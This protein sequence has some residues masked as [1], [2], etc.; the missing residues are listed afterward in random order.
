MKTA[1]I[2]CFIFTLILTAG[3]VSAKETTEP[4]SSGSHLIV[5]DSNTAG[6]KY[7]LSLPPQYGSKKQRWPLI[8]RLHGAGRRG[9]DLKKIENNML[10]K[11]AREDK[12]FPFIVLCPQCPKGRRWSSG[13]LIKLLDDV[14][15]RY[16]VDI[17]RIYVTGPS[18]G[19]YGTW[20]LACDYPKRFAAIAP[21]CGGGL[22]AKAC[23]LKNVAVW[24]FHGAKDKVVPLERSQEMVNAANA[25]GGNANLTV[26]PNKG[27]G[28][29]TGGK[30]VAELTHANTKLYKWFLEHRRSGKA[31]SVSSTDV[32]S[33]TQRHLQEF[34][35]TVGKNTSKCL[36][37]LPK[38]FNREQLWPLMVFL[39]GGS[40]RGDDL[41]KVKPHVHGL[42][43]NV[44]NGNYPFILVA[45]QCPKGRYWS[46]QVDMLT[47]LLDKV[48]STY[49]VDPNRIYLTGMSMG[50]HGTWDLAAEHPNRFAA[51]AP[52]C[53]WPSAVP[54]KACNLKSLPVWAFHGAKDD[55]APLEKSQE[56]VNA[57]NT[58]G[59]SIN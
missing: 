31:S 29:S 43:E 5:A 13:M 19:G 14:I 49:S 3:S 37:Y 56:M 2:T 26:Y 7:L 30:T 44:I 21:I 45:P 35:T 17:D 52:I 22:P 48:I 12:D 39:H 6:Y 38:D 32:L 36:L 53:C 1:F 59:G 41:E 8:L 28:R 4:Q 15:T 25:C 18:M 55:V 42:L 10:L 20:N 9:D 47:G 24:A 33:V 23:N 16:D 11:V 54:E 27:H 51:I 46:S 57:V 40:G 34:Q 50:G 58:C